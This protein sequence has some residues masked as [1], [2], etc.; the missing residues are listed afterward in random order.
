MLALNRGDRGSHSFNHSKDIQKVTLGSFSS[1]HIHYLAVVS[2]SPLLCPSLFLTVSSNSVRDKTPTLSALVT[3]I[4][5]LLLQSQLNGWCVHT[6]WSHQ[7]T[8][9]CFKGQEPRVH[10]RQGYPA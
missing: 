3:T 4:V 10:R 8:S 1:V 7:T 9:L 5:L 6:S 2:V